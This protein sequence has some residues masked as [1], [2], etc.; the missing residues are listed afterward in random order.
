MTRLQRILCVL[1]GG[2][3]AAASGT[4]YVV[5]AE[6]EEGRRALATAE[7]TYVRWLEVRVQEVAAQGR[8]RELQARTFALRQAIASADH[9]LAQARGSQ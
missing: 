9:A 6:A 2:I 3:T 1:L 4:A 8:L 7:R 5:H